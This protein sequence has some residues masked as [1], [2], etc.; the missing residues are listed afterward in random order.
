MSVLDELLPVLIELAL[1]GEVGT[2]NLTNPG[3]ISHNEILTIY[4]EIY[5]LEIYL[6]NLENEKN[7]DFYNKLL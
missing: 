4:K 3:L 2:I 1:K 6:R 5:R 7:S